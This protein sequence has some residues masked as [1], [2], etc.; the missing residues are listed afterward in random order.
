MAP[1]EAIAGLL[2]A[3]TGVEAVLL[4]A[5]GRRCASARRPSTASPCTGC[6]GAL[7]ALADDLGRPLPAATR[8]TLGSDWV[9]TALRERR[10]LTRVA[11]I[12]AGGPLTGAVPPLWTWPAALRG[13]ISAGAT[14]VDGG[15]EY[16]GRSATPLDVEAVLRFLDAVS[17]L[18]EAVAVVGVFSPIAADDELAVAELVHRELGPAVP[19]SL[20]HEIGS[21]GLLERENATA[22]NAA[23]VGPA[24]VLAAALLA[25]LEERGI[26]AEPFLTQNDGSAMVLE[27]AAR[28]PGRMLGNGPALAMNGAM[29]MSGVADGVV[30]DDDGVRTDIG[31][32]AGGVLRE[33]P[34]DITETAGV[35]TTMRRPQVLRLAGGAAP[36]AARPAALRDALDRSGVLR[37]Q[38]TVVA[39]GTGAQD[40]AAGLA[41]MEGIDVVVPADAG[42]AGAIGAARASVAGQVEVFC[43]HEG[44]GAEAAIARA[45]RAAIH[46][47]ADPERVHVVEVEQMPL[48]YLVA[49]ALRIRARAEGPCI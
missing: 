23:L 10:G 4:D 14:I 46:A 28:Y 1:V 30:A 24:R 41:D 45:R 35:R 42:V 29:W 44:Q 39:I 32:L 21:L 16:D 5:H 43:E 40:V 47:G 15:A 48:G 13:A 36:G 17:D 22:L 37:G 8:V 11:V 3:T 33:E 25:V 31:V 18:A 49:P 2:S 7:D 19:V 26:R 6:A 20:G 9:A 34:D 12:R 38:A 27:H